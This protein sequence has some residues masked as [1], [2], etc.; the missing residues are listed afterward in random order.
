MRLSGKTHAKLVIPTPIREPFGFHINH[1][2]SLPSQMRQKE[3]NINGCPQFLPLFQA[4][5]SD[6]LFAQQSSSS[7][8]K[9][10]SLS[11]LFTDPMFETYT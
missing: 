2:D 9:F 11:T 1:G 5:S 4:Q 7:S 10:F 6:I 8:G 3:I